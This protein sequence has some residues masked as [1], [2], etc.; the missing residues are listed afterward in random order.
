MT[1]TKIF[2]LSGLHCTSCSLVIEGEIED[3]GAKASCDYVKQTVKVEFDPEILSEQ[4]IIAAI[5]GQGYEVV[6]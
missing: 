2:K 1:T 5:E 4:K 3:L 6:G